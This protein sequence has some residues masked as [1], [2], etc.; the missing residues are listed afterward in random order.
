MKIVKIANWSTKD[1]SAIRF[2]CG[3]ITLTLYKTF[4][5]QPIFR[6]MP[7]LHLLKNETII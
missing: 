1:Y 6:P 2:D 7:R 5:K 4:A 3:L